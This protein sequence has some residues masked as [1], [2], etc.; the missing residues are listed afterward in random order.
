MMVRTHL[1]SGFS[2]RFLCVLS[3]SGVNGLY[4]QQPGRGPMIPPI[5][6]TGYQAILDGKSLAGWD[7]DPKFWRVEN[8]ALRLKQYPSRDR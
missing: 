4:S 3:V 7:G 8:G 2:L 5:E 1:T 6:E